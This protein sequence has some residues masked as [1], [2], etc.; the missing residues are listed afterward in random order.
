MRASGVERGAQGADDPRQ[1]PREIAVLAAAEAE[2]LHRDG[3][4]EEA[5]R[6]V[7]RRERHALR[8]REQLGDARVTV[9]VEVGGDARPIDRQQRAVAAI[10]LAQRACVGDS[11]LAPA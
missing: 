5:R 2:A 10:R 9:R 4:A 1:R 7:E 6:A 8:R 11:W 3:A